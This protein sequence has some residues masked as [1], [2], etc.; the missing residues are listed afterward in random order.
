MMTLF[1]ENYVIVSAFGDKMEC[2][3]VMQSQVSTERI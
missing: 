2:L 1:S 3:D